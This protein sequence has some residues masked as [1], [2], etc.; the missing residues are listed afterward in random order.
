MATDCLGPG[1]AGAV[2]Q[3]SRARYGADE[4]FIRLAEVTGT[5]G[6]H[7]LH[8]RKPIRVT[9]SPLPVAEHGRDLR[10]PR[11][12]PAHGVSRVLRRVEAGEPLRVSVSGRPVAELSP[13]PRRRT[14]LTW[15]DFLDT[16]VPVRAD[17]AC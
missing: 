11:S 7:D 14:W 5:A 10:N 3:H 9:R 13:V 15:S 6:H 2:E 8:V 12:R 17:P 4:V 1:N 16:V